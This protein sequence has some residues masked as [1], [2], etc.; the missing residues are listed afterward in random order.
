MRNVHNSRNAPKTPPV[1]LVPGPKI[2]N[3]C[4]FSA[5]YLILRAPNLVPEYQKN[6]PAPNMNYSIR[7]IGF[8]AKWVTLITYETPQ[9]ATRRPSI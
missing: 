2:K 4:I 5:I 8:P 9:N 7:R 3:K 6:T 1:F